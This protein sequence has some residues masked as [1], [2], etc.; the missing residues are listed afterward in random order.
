MGIAQREVV[1][2]H[3][4]LLRSLRKHVQRKVLEDYSC[5]SATRG[6]R[7]KKEQLGKEGEKSKL[8]QKAGVRVK[9]TNRKDGSKNKD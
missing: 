9:G 8:S 1:I 6:K 7:T 3:T 4:V 5:F 2:T